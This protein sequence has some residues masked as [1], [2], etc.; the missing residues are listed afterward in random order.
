MTKITEIWPQL[1]ETAAGWEEKPK[2]VVILGDVYPVNS[3]RDVLRRTAE[4]AAQWCGDKFEEQVVAELPSY[5]SREQM[6]TF[7]HPACRRASSCR[8]GVGSW[9]ERRIY[10]TSMVSS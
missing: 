6:K 5:F 3:W 4:V 8:S 1:G 7:A 10:P 9:S 2:A